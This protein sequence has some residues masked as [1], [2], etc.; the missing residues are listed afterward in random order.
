MIES[1]LEFGSIV[2]RKEMVVGTSLSVREV[3]LKCGLL[4]ATSRMIA[5]GYIP[6]SYRLSYTFEDTVRT[7]HKWDE[8]SFEKVSS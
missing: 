3:P 2:W 5:V 7:Y 4:M 6:Y 1:E 8:T